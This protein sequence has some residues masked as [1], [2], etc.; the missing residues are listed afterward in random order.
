MPVIIPT[1]FTAFFFG[2]TYGCIGNIEGG[3]RG[4]VIG[5]FLTSIISGITPALLIKFGS[6]L[7]NGTT[8]GGSDSA[9]IGI[10]YTQTGKLL[11]ATG[12]LILTIILFL[13]P[14]LYSI[15]TRKKPGITERGDD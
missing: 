4:V 7:V 2:A 3:M 5:S 12:I 6:V 9:L 14:I 1:L 15:L 13:L 11:P 10:F 8:F